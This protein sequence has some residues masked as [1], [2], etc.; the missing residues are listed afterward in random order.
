MLDFC[1]LGA[2]TSSF[3]FILICLKQFRKIH[4]YRQWITLYH[5]RHLF[6]TDLFHITCNICLHLYFNVYT[7]KRVPMVYKLHLRHDK[8][9]REN[10]QYEYGNNNS[11]TY[12]I[13]ADHCPDVIASRIYCLSLADWN[14][15]ILPNETD[16][17]WPRLSLYL[18][19]LW[20]VPVRGM[21]YIGKLITFTG[22]WTCIGHYGTHIRCPHDHLWRK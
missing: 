8:N 18:D 17:T 11:D 4:I 1:F 14:L 7:R 22:S 6:H 9:L 16:K 21:W 19:L 20:D 13:W 12:E 2:T 15:I 3:V 10:V 5:I